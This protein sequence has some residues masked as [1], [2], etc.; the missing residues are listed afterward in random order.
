MKRETSTLTLVMALLFSL[1][2]GASVNLV[3]ANPAPLFSFPTEPITTPPTIVVTS[4]VQNQTCNTKVGF[5]LTIIKPEA[6]FAIDVG[7]HLNGSPINQIFVNITSVYYVVDNSERQN[8][9]VYDVDSLFDVAPIFTLNL[10]TILPLKTGYHSIR[11]GLEADSYYVVRYVYNLSE[12]LSSVRICAESDAVYFTVAKPEPQ[13]EPF[14][15]TLVVS[16]S[17][18]VALITG[19]LLVY[20]RSRKK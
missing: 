11:V 4:P 5:S 1:A 17:A 16:S 15:T 14:P 10:S 8:I 3:K 12:A 2:V 19:G 9:T 13:P 18:S 6:W 7:H 20:F